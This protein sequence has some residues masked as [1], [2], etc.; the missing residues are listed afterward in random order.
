MEVISTFA[1]QSLARPPDLLHNRVTSRHSVRLW[2]NFLIVIGMCADPLPEERPISDK[3]SDRA[4]IQPDAH[5]PVLV[6]DLLEVQRR[7][8]SILLPSPVGPPS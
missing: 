3:L 6:P 1:G 2:L 7:M 8:E 4:V 5:R